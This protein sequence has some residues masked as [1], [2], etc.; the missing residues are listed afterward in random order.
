MGQGC[1]R[2]A[3]AGGALLWY[4]KMVSCFGAW[5]LFLLGEVGGL[6]F[7]PFEA[8]STPKYIVPPNCVLL[9]HGLFD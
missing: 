1:S 4:G 8:E 7:A 6:G 5:L 2:L 3:G 9:L